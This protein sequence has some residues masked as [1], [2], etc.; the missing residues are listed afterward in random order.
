[1]E[2]FAASLFEGGGDTVLSGEFFAQTAPALVDSVFFEFF[3]DELH[4]LV[5]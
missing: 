5:G 3:A 2:G 1:M 4:G